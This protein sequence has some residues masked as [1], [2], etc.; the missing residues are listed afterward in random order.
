MMRDHVMELTGDPRP[1]L[2]QPP[3]RHQLALALRL[4]HPRTRLGPQ[5]R[6]RLPPQPKHRHRRERGQHGQRR[7]RVNP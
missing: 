3:L 2:D 4:Q 1:L 6:T 7:R 5:A